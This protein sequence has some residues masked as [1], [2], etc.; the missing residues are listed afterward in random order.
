[1]NRDSGHGPL[2][3]FTGL[4]IAGAGLLAA[5]A[6]MAVH[7][8]PP[9]TGAL[10]LGVVLLAAGL[11]QSLAHLGQK[12]R[13][14]AALRRVGRSALSNEILIASL[15]LSSAAVLLAM[16][17][18]SGPEVAV[19]RFVAGAFAGWFLVSIGLVYRLPGQHTW[20][21][22]VVLTP[23]TAG[24]AVGAILIQT[25]WV[26]GG[27]L[28]VTVVAIVLD[29]AAFVLRWRDVAAAPMP[30]KSAWSMP[31]GERRRWLAARLLLLD[32]I[33]LFLV[34]TGLAWLAI[35]A[36]AA[37]LWAD[38]FGFYALAVQHTTE[39][40]IARVEHVVESAS[41]LHNG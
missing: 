37:G 29:A 4:G 10:A 5:D 13:A 20:R 6:L 19:A 22:A 34:G 21:G 41:T 24:C 30:A 27:P 23:L 1:M 31:V 7:A 28:G 14:P 9:H 38:R 17:L 32:V 25:V 18:L 11:L 15:A 39:A 2:V 8:R 36:A 40:E 26:H 3:A 16:V 35:P 12:R 33:P